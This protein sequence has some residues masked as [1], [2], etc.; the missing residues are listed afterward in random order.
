[1]QRC[2]I[3][4]AIL[5]NNPSRPGPKCYWF[6]ISRPPFLQGAQGGSCDPAHPLLSS[7]QPDEV[8]F[9]CLGQRHPVSIMAKSSW[10]PFHSNI[11]WKVGGGAGERLA[12]D[13]KSTEWYQTLN[14]GALA[15]VLQC[16]FNWRLHILEVQSD[17]QWNVSNRF[18]PARAA[19]LFGLIPLPV[20]RAVLSKHVEG[21]SYGK[22]LLWRALSLFNCKRVR[23]FL[24]IWSWTIL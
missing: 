5:R 15:H 9:D 19:M 16:Y 17:I 2:S 10:N 20:I 7:Q 12:R 14:Q 13:P 4:R 6:C 24:T 18:V 8:C 1:M 3:W 21:S 11:T 22:S 23:I